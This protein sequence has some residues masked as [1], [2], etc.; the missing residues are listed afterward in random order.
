ME[1]R[2]DVPPRA[3]ERRSGGL[4]KGLAKGSSSAAVV[5]EM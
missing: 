5:L 4:G 1:L 2:A 3:F